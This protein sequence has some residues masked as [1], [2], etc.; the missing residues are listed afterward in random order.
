MW[1]A[2]HPTTDTFKGFAAAMVD[3]NKFL[4]G[5][6][7]ET[8]GYTVNGNSDDWMYGEQT[9]KGKISINDPRGRDL[10]F[11]QLRLR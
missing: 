2:L 10:N 7:S 3:E 11:G 6:G 8:V 1:M 5:Y 4:A 9:T